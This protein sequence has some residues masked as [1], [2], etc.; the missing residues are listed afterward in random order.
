MK[1]LRRKD[2]ILNLHVLHD[3]TRQPDML[4]TLKLSFASGKREICIDRWLT[5]QEATQGARQL[6]SR[7]QVDRARCRQRLRL[8]YH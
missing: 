4:V 3:G 8:R 6:R 1:E 5:V 7:R 2:A